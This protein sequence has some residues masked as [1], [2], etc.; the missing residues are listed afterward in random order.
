[1]PQRILLVLELS[2]LTDERLMHK[3]RTGST[4]SVMGIIQ[5]SC[6]LLLS[7]RDCE[8]LRARLP[9]SVH[10]FDRR[11]KKGLAVPFENHES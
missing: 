8:L 5:L 1:M 10:H 3:A 4:R 9:R 7:R 6:S 11:S 2:D